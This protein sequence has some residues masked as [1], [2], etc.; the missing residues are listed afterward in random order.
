M[1]I[2]TLLFDILI[3]LFIIWLV[4]Y[5]FLYCDVIVVSSCILAVILVNCLNIAMV[6]LFAK[7]RGNSV[8]SDTTDTLINDV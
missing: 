6:Y 3:V 1:S 7:L 4:W 2:G 8:Q 5:L